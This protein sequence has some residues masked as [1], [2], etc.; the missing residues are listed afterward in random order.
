M[1]ISATTMLR[2]CSATLGFSLLAASAAGAVPLVYV[3][4]GESSAEAVQESANGNV[5]PAIALFGERTGI[6]SPSGLAVSPTGVVAI[7]VFDGGDRIRQRINLFARGASGNV[8]PI[9]T[10]IC[11][12]LGG[13]PEQVAFDSQGSLYAEYAG[14]SRKGSDAI[15]VFAPGHQSGCVKD[16]HVIFGPR[17]SVDALSGITV[18]RGTIYNGSHDVNGLHAAVRE[19]RTTDHGNVAPRNII[20]GLNTGLQFVGGLAVDNNGYLYVANSTSNAAEIR[21]F[22]PS[23][24]GDVAPIAIIAGNRTRLHYVSSVTVSRDGRIFVAS[25]PNDTD[26]VEIVVF[27][28]GAHGNAS[29]IQVISGSRTGF[30]FIQEIGLRE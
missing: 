15:E 21:M 22:S 6:E 14:Y 13:V 25:S 8:F 12:G 20:Q 7:P 16:T 17:T 5:P 2:I 27:A 18:A 24:H 19:F 29:P 10:I 1:N 28:R 23:A 4:N 30:S 26:A 9:G 11:A 3:L